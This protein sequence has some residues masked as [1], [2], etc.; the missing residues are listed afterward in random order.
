M[1]IADSWTSLPSYFE[2]EYR[3]IQAR[4][5]Y[6]AHTHQSIAKAQPSYLSIKSYF[7]SSTENVFS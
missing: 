6:A 4:S 2:S 1:T 5:G 3:L 7:S